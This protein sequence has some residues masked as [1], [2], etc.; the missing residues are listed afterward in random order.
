M[1]AF[2]QTIVTICCMKTMNL[3]FSKPF[4]KKCNEEGVESGRQLNSWEDFLLLQRMRYPPE[5]LVLDLMSNGTRHVLPIG[6]VSV[7]KHFMSSPRNKNK[8]P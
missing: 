1:E 4:G 3:V 6:Y 7:G 2:D 5:L 8:S